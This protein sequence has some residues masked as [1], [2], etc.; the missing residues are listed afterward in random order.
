MIENL[1]SSTAADSG[2]DQAHGW[3]RLLQ[4]LAAIALGLVFLVA[5]AAKGG[6][7]AAFVEQI[8]SYA[9]VTGALARLAAWV[10][11]PFE[12][13]LAACLIFGFRRRLAALATGLLLI[14]FMAVT[15]YGWSQGRMEGCGCFGALAS[16]G[17]GGV[18]SED[19][20]LLVLAVIAWLPVRGAGGLFSE[21]A[22]QRHGLARLAAVVLLTAIS[23]AYQA[24]APALPL[25]DYVTALRPGRQVA[26][27][28]LGVALEGEEPRLVALLDL[29]SPEIQQTVEALSGL[30]SGT[31]MPRQVAFAAANE[32][33]RGA[34]FFGFG[35]HTE[36]AEH[37]S[38]RLLY[39]KLPR[40]FLASGGR[41]VETWNDGPPTPEQVAE[42]LGSAQNE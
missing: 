7:P 14:F 18:I 42:A 24:A 34:F 35:I 28:G 11:I 2:G 1:P 16:R 29:K 21:P 25:D 38:M 20:V 22:G 9:I 10:L 27:L 36:E 26:D 39:R 13:L 5:A 3:P 4:V 33:E 17:P 19:T 31:G 6:D 37:T 40:F 12:T 30:A 41:V 8:E 32:E 23:I 15:A